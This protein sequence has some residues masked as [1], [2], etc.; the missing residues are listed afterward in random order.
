MKPS[1]HKKEWRIMIMFKWEDYGKITMLFID[2][3]SEHVA[4]Y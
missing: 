2:G 1:F 4:Q 3:I